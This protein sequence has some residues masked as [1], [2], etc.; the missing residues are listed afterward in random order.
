MTDVLLAYIA[1][2]FT[3]YAAREWRSARA[4]RDYVRP[5]FTDIQEVL[6]LQEEMKQGGTLDQRDTVVASVRGEHEKPRERDELDESD[7]SHDLIVALR[8]D[9][10]VRA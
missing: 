10:G 4:Y 3:I 9:D 6:L 5:L 7:L 1:V 8:S 2:A